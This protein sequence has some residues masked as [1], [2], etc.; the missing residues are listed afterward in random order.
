VTIADVYAR[1][2][3]RS[4]N[5]NNPRELRKALC[6]K[7]YIALTYENSDWPF[8]VVANQLGVS[9]DGKLGNEV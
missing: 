1:G 5:S 8:F 9:F 6:A 7:L 4:L 2:L 3:I